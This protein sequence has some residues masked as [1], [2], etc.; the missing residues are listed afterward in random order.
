MIKPAAKQPYW[1][2][3]SGRRAPCLLTRENSCDKYI[4]KGLIVA[5]TTVHYTEKLFS[6]PVA[7]VGAFANLIPVLSVSSL[8]LFAVYLFWCRDGSIWWSC[9]SYQNRYESF[10]CRSD[11]I[12]EFTMCDSGHAFAVPQLSIKNLICICLNLLSWKVAKVCPVF[13]SYSKGSFVKYQPIL[14]YQISLR[15]LRYFFIIIYSSANFLVPA[16]TYTDFCKTFDFLYHGKLLSQ[17]EIYGNSS[18]SLCFLESYL[19]IKM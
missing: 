12:P 10:G 13:K 17:L 4:V 8:R 9:W 3:Y 16:C 11:G 6:D 1:K 19:F 2:Y 7:F 14:F 15:F 18:S 5:I